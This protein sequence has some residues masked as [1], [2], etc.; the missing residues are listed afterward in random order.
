[1][2]RKVIRLHPGRERS[3]ERRHPWVYSGA[4]ADVTGD[5]GPGD[6]VEIETASGA[7]L[8]RGAYSPASQIRARVWTWDRDQA[9]DEALLARRLSAA[10]DARQAL[11][12]APGLTAY[13]EVH[14]ESDGI[15][16][17]IVDRYNDFR[18]VQLLTAGIDGWR[19]GIAAALAA[20]G[21]CRGV[22]ERSDVPVRPL[23]GLPPRMGRLWGEEPDE[24]LIVLEHGLKF[25]V[26]VRR[27]H[28]TGFYLDQRENRQLLRRGLEDASVLNCFAYTGGFGVAALE[29]GASHVLSIE[30]SGSALEMAARNVELN[31]HSMDRCAW[32]EGDA[33]V[34][35]RR[36]RDRGLH[37]D[38]VV[39]DPPRFAAT[40]AHAD[41]AA[42]GY[43]DINLLAFKLLHPGGRLYTFSCSGGVSPE[44]FQKIVA[45]AALDAGVEVSVIGW[46][47]QPEDH[48]VSLAFPEGRYLK[49]L[50]CRVAGQP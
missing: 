25:L 2:D 18:I 36:L 26:D 37:F 41:R 34:E 14:A 10:I 21:D 30:A 6:I 9:V 28:K 31:G 35:L 19:E 5:P 48:P 45:G 49:G 24:E 1:M 3:L 4:I 17:L 27:G 16:G 32:L 50:L 40:V 33:F 7:W 38:V 20:R 11:A 12:C 22:Y 44:L 23:E 47:G 29:G 43:K 15:P 8:A 13:R 39:L 46:L 42:R